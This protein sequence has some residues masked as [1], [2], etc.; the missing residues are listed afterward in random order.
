MDSGALAQSV[1]LGE[2][3]LPSGMFWPFVTTPLTTLWKDDAHIQRTVS[4]TL[5]V[6][7]AGSKIRFPF[8]PTMT[9]VMEL[10]MVVLVVVVGAGPVVGVVV[11]VVVVVTVVLVDGD[12]FATT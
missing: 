5:M 3:N 6:T 10:P 4:P 8:G 12:S 7:V 11:G 9:V 2:Q 1:S